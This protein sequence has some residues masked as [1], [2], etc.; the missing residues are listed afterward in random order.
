[1]RRLPRRRRG[2][3]GQALL[4]ALLALFI[5]SLAAGLVAEDL[6]LRE[7]ALQEEAARVHVRGLL[8]GALADALARLDRHQPLQDRWTWGGGTTT[9]EAQ[10]VTATQLTLRV[11]ATYAAHH[12]AAEAAVAITVDGP[13]VTS[14]Q[15]THP[16][17]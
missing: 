15:R 7:K 4:F 1:V 11:T 8:D 16:G 9:S 13:R 2:E 17:G 3:S 10:Y 14:W 5:A 12:G 6:R